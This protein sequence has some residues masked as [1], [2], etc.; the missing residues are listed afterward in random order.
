MDRIPAA[1]TVRRPERAAE[2]GDDSP[3]SSVF[4]DEPVPQVLAEP[5]CQIW[6][7][8][9]RRVRSVW[10][11]APS[12]IYVL[13]LELGKDAEITVGALGGRTFRA[14]RHFYAGRAMRGL[15][16]RLAR[17]VRR[18]KDRPRWHIDH[19][20]A[21]ARLL[22]ISV[23]PADDPSLECWIAGRL[24]A[25]GGRVE[26]PG[27]GSSDCACPAHLFSYAS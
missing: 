14:G 7:R 25:A 5:G 22:T 20:R 13:A 2:G 3:R 18:T 8:A 24:L 16:A 4:P 12:G 23:L 10:G 27:F 19:L 1:K 17:H 15:E 26:V 6:F 11:A 21:R 9:G